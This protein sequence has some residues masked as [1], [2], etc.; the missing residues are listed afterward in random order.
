MIVWVNGA[1]GSGKSTLVDELR[2]RWPEALVYD[3]EM[4][5]YVLREIVEVPTGDFQDLRL[6][7]RQV[8]DLA[9]G[10]VEEYRRPV[11]VPMT[12]VNPGYVG[13]IFG[14]LKDAGI[15]V[16][17]FFLKVSREVLEE[18]I[19]GRSFTPDNP[20]QDE[21]VRRWCKARIEPCMAGADALPSDTVFLDGEL[22]PQRL[23]DQ[24]LAQV[25]AGGP[26]GA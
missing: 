17:H 26:S 19:D 3:P 9:V 14:V 1:F 10:L 12:V 2:P 16:H 20:E 11:L 24:V 5:G 8:G 6:W 23:A 21:R 25:R 22:P 13:E 7:R 15:D 18:R 4:V